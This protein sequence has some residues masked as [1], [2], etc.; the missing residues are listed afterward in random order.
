[1]SGFTSGDCR[2]PNVSN[3]I[4]NLRENFSRLVA[5]NQVVV[6]V[7]G[8]WFFGFLTMVCC[9]VKSLVNREFIFLFVL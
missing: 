8:I 1:M 6:G 5:R 9:D 2:N 7:I 3:F 4:A